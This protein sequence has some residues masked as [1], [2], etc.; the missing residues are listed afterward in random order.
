MVHTLDF[1]CF[2]LHCDQK[3]EW[4]NRVSKPSVDA[5]GVT[6]HMDVT[7]SSR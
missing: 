4:F 2:Y 1:P 7:E 5:I 3:L 6:E